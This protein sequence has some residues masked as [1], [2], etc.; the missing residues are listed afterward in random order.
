MFSYFSLC[1]R[2]EKTCK[3]DIRIFISITRDRICGSKIATELTN[4]ATIRFERNL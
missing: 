4:Y 1:S 3:K 2:S